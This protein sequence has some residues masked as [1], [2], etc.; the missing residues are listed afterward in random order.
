MWLKIT[1]DAI[2]LALQEALVCL[3]AY[4]AGFHFTRAVGGAPTHIGALWSVISGIVVLQAT[5]RETVAQAWLRV[6]GTLVGS[7]VSAAYLSLLPFSPVGMAVSIGITVLLCHTF[8]ISDHAR[9]AALTVAVIMVVSLADP[10]MNPLLNA[11]LR[12]G[13][14]CIGT[15]IAVLAVVLWPEHHMPVKPKEGI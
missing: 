13:E 12:F 2:R 11:G 10:R 9:L 14:S 5:R 3:A 8:R 4:L 6:L 1:P 7:M 15:G